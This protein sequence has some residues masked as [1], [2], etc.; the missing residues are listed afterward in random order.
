LA[1]HAV[2][3]IGLDDDLSRYKLVVAPMV[4][5]LRPGFAER[6]KQ[7]VENGGAFVAT[8]LS[9]WVDENSLV[10]EGG[11]LAPLKGVL[12]VRS[13]EIDVLHPDQ[14][15][16]VEVAEES[17]WCP[18]GRYQVR[19]FCELVHCDTAEPIGVY[20]EDFYAG[21]AAVTSNRFGKG[22]AFYVAS[23]NDDAFLEAF[24]QT[25]AKQFGVRAA[26]N[27]ELPEGVTAL[28]RTDEDSDSVFIL[29]ANPYDVTIPTSDWGPVTV[30]SRNVA[31]LPRPKE[32]RKEGNEERVEARA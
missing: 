20:G 16:V 15:N 10:Y 3:I 24:L 2:D 4:Y 7:F 25:V 9:A 17:P 1:G 18:A 29:N 32:P 11:F 19:D 6:V 31:I 23:R 5:S 13:E 27:T 22:R 8:Y 21:R 30:A 14:S 26:L 12:G 28:C